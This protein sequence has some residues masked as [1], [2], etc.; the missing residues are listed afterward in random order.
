[1]TELEELCEKALYRELQSFD[2]GRSLVMDLSSDQIYY[3]KVLSVYSIPVFSWLKEHTHPNIPHISAF[4]EQDGKLVVIEEQI[5]GKT[6]E[7]LLDED[8]LPF[9][10]KK[11][12][13]LA[14][15]DG[16]TFLHSA[17]PPIIHRDLKASNIMV[18]NDGAVK[19]ID[20]DAAKIYVKDAKRDTVLIGTQGIA[21]PEQYGFGASD[22]RTDIYA[23]G[24]LVER[25]FPDDAAA[26]AI[27][28]KA[29][30]MEPSDR[31]A[32]VAQARAK[33]ARLKEG[34]S[35][36]K[37]GSSGEKS[38]AKTAADGNPNGKGIFGRAGK[39]R[40]L[41]AA[42][43]LA[44]AA[45][46]IL[47]VSMHS[48]GGDDMPGTE[49]TGASGIAVK[50]TKIQESDSEQATEPGTFSQ[51]ETTDQSEPADGIE[52][53][54]QT[55]TADHT[56]TTTELTTESR[57]GTSEAPT[58]STA[59]EGT[60]LSWHAELTLEEGEPMGDLRVIKLSAALTG[61]PKGEAT[62]IRFEIDVR[63]TGE[64]LSNTTE[65]TFTSGQ[66]AEA[67]FTAPPKDPNGGKEE[68]E[69]FAYSDSGDLIGE[70]SGAVQ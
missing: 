48:C 7:Q 40:L 17:E 37:S 28:E 27:V 58:E 46:I 21:A 60:D 51:L 50:T 32:N 30:R 18:T 14:V 31:Y 23:L 42:A 6:L 59:A 41:T 62:H 33:I 38:R 35:S 10:K 22:E 63:S 65:D 66:T 61:G 11:R 36:G 54:G 13:L 20:Y 49:G 69:I 12:I 25:L 24:K 53:A 34:G 8:T 3:K 47:F 67:M 26:A 44:A 15:C 5:N 52:T 1:M 55:G 56:E 68:Y 29:T 19:L 70:Y 16:L 9:E 64:H 43:V 45:L 2:D 39:K 4:W 57:A